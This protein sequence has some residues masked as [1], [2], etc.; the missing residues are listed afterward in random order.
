MKIK[1]NLLF[2]LLFLFSKTSFSDQSIAVVTEEGVLQYTKDNRV[3][4]PAT[5]I[6]KGVLDL[7]PFQ[8]KI[9][10]LPWTRAYNNAILKPNTLIYSMIRNPERE[11]MFH[12]IGKITDTRFSLYALKSSNIKINNLE[13]ARHYSIG[14]V[15]DDIS[16][17]YLTKQGF[18][19]LSFVSGFEQNIKKFLSGRFDL[20]ILQSYE[21]KS[22]RLNC[23]N[24]EEVHEVEQLSLGFYMALSKPTPSPVVDLLKL[25]YNDFSASGRI[26]E[27]LAQTFK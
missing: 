14:V 16:H 10:S 4:G 6:V 27:I 18:T 7:T 19:K 25:A 11:Q 17:L 9:R 20:I 12:W 24:F 21:C 1:F 26:E 5:E 23:E 2:L 8:Y 22:E 13:D 15:K 3:I